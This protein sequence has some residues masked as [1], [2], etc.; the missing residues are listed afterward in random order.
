LLKCNGLTDYAFTPLTFQ[1]EPA[2]AVRCGENVIGRLLLVPAEI[3]DF[4][5][6]RQVVVVVE[7]DLEQLQAKTRSKPVY[8]PLAKY[9]AV[10]RDFAVVLRENIPVGDLLNAVRQAHRFIEEVSIFDVFRGAGIGNDLKSIAFS[11]R[12][13]KLE[14]TLQEAEIEQISSEILGVLKRKFGAVLR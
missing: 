12:L 8:R 10:D 6:I 13:Q 1:D 11:V 4:Y 2:A 9:P 3:L 7:L 5:N 14:A